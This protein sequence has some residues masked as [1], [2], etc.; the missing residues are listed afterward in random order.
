M[1]KFS[2]F[3]SESLHGDTDWR[4]IA[5]IVRYLPDKKQQN[6]GSLSN[7]RCQKPARASPY[8]LAH[9]VQSFIEIGSLSAEL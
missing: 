4:Q 2:E 7:C 3:C 1:L 8:H 5:E 6:L 9:S